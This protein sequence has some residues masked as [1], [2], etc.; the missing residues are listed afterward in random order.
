MCDGRRPA[1]AALLLCLRSCCA[2]SFAVVRPLQESRNNFLSRT[3]HCSI[4]FYERAFAVQNVTLYIEYKYIQN[5]DMYM[6]C[7]RLGFEFFFFDNV[8]QVDWLIDCGRINL[9]N[10][11]QKCTFTELCTIFK[12]QRV[13]A[14]VFVCV[15]CLDECVMPAF[16]GW[17]E[18]AV[19]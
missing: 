10:R 16:C 19:P 12:G 8:N 4:Y 15:L 6:K 2:A 13:W 5:T 1:D 17:E 7:R 14:C 9:N 3:S 18:C 11:L